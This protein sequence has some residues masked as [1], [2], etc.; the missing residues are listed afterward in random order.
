MFFLTSIMIVWWKTK[1]CPPSK[2]QS[3]PLIRTYIMHTYKE[4]KE[5]RQRE[6][7]F[8]WKTNFVSVLTILLHTW[9]FL[10]NF[11]FQTSL[12]K[13]RACP[14]IQLQKSMYFLSFFLSSFSWRHANG[15]IE[16]IHVRN[17]LYCRYWTQCK[18]TVFC[19]RTC[20][21]WQL[22]VKLSCIVHI[23]TSF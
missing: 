8:K 21:F 9:I 6:I 10:H 20:D 2:L 15:N 17:L 1:N 19:K 13:I 23:H 12:R 14:V 18:R 11:N 7:E 3:T 5:K 22:V 16:R 4:D